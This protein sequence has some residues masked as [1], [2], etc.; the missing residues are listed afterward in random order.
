M[1]RSEFRCGDCRFYSCEKQ[2]DKVCE[3]LG[4]LETSVGC[5]KFKPNVKKLKDSLQ[6]TGSSIEL[7]AQMV[8]KVPSS[9]LH[10]LSSILYNDK[11]TRKFGYRFMQR[12]YVRY[13]GL[14]GANYVSNF[15]PAHVIEAS[16]AG[17]RLLSASGNTHIL[18]TDF[19]KGELAGPNIFS[20]TEF[21]K[22]KQEMV[23]ANKLE[24][25]ALRKKKV[26]QDFLLEDV[27]PEKSAETKKKKKYAIN[28]LV[29]MTKDIERGYLTKGT[30]KKS[31][32]VENDVDH[33]DVI[34]V[35]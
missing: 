5:E 3:Q 25:P 32:P 23:K 19:K 20:V 28:D 24:D 12:V 31:K 7:L 33:E 29:S 16:K 2:F 18:K 9:S 27:V 30:Y 21:K 4:H 14:D 13:R 15:M 22:L 8:A 11:T 6:E 10:V 34:T 17:L 35:K 1:K 26:S